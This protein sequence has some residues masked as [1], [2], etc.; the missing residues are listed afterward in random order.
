MKSIIRDVREM[1]QTAER[2]RLSGK[3]ISVVPTMGFLHK[4]HLSLIR[5]AKMK[6]D[7]VVTTLFVNPKQFGPNED[8]ER[9][10]RAFEHDLALADAEGTDYLFAP[11]PAFMYPVGYATYVSVEGITDVLEGKSRPGHFRGVATVVAKLLNLTK[12][13]LAVFGQKDAQQVAVIRRM[14]RDLNFDV[15]LVIAPTVREDDGLAMSSRN[16][17]LTPQQRKEATVLFQALKHAEQ[18]VKDGVRD[19]STI[20]GEMKALITSKSSGVVDYISIADNNSLQ[21]LATLQLR[22]SVL[23]SLAVRFGTTR[24]IDN[25]LLLV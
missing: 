15:E 8:Y 24:L 14:V 21:E 9:Y 7:I 11:D 16:T 17:Y 18:R 12:P 2:L 1:R 20:V 6:S 13:H 19:C 5:I 10:P 4:G 25:V 3:R 22:Q 23:I